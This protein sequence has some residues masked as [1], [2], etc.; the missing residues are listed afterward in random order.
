MSTSMT[1]GMRPGAVC[2][3]RAGPCIT[4]RVLGHEDA[5]TT[6]IYLN[7]TVNELSDSMRRYGTGSGLLHDVAH[8]ADSEP[9]PHVQQSD[10]AVSN[11]LVN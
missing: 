8:G 10:A 4:S 6:S 1:S 9:P 2:S 5:K 3:K 7:A 11:P